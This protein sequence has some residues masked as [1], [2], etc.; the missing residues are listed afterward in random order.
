MDNH[1]PEL[2]EVETI[3]HGIDSILRGGEITSLKYYRDNLRDEIPKKE[4]KKILDGQKVIRVFRRSKYILIETNVGFAMIHLGMTGNVLHFETKKPQLLHTHVVLSL[5]DANGEDGY[6]HYVDPRRFGRFSFHF[7]ENYKEHPL[8][9]KLGPEPLECRN[10][11]LHLFKRS[12]GRKTPVKTFVMDAH[13]VVGVGNI[14]ACESLFKTKISPIRL[15][16]SLTEEEFC[17]LAIS[18]KKT[19]RAAIKAGGTTLKDFKNTEG[20]SGYFAIS[21]KVYGKGKKPC[22]ECGNPINVIRQSGRS[23]FFCSFCQN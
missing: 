22:I 4:L 1:V 5:K 23:T 8:L 13:N 15:A 7:G 17:Q 9:K 11:G 10:L 12:R 21:L 16:G 19:L 20:K 6:L 3:C 18:I 14:Y 2:P